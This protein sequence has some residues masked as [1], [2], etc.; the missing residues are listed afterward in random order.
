MRISRAIESLRETLVWAIAEIDAGNCD[1]SDETANFLNH[2]ICSSFRSECRLSKYQAAQ[3]MNMSTRQFDRYIGY[4]II[5]K[6]KKAPGFKELSW[7]KK[8]LDKVNINR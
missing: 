6:G 8:D 4:G 7:S 3:Y 5:P 1:L 2:T